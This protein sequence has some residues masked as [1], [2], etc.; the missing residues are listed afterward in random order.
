M[1]AVY[2]TEPKLCTLSLIFC[3]A[4]L[5]ACGN[6]EPSEMEMFDAMKNSGLDLIR[7]SDRTD[8]KKGACE[9][10]GEKTFKCGVGS[11]TGKGMTMNFSFVKVDGKWQ[12]SMN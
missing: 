2:S 11:N 6:S 4:L 5:A 7:E 1:K 10:A 12:M 8:F 3:A 9:K